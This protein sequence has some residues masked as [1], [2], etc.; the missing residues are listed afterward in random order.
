VIALFL[1]LLAAPKLQPCQVPG[2]DE[3]VHCGRYEVYENRAAR[4]GRK[5]ALKIVVL[6]ATG[7]RATSDPLVFLAGG[8]VAPATRY[9]AF[10]GNA[11]PNLR[12]QRDILLVDQ[13]G[14]GGSN[15]LDCEIS[16]DRT[17]AEYRDEARFRA[18]VRRC[19]AQLEAKADVR[20]YTT[21]LAMDDL[22]DVRA[23]L[24]YSRLNLYGASYG[25]SAAMVYV[26]QHPTRVRTITL[27][28]VVP[29]D[30]QMWIEIPRSSEEVLRHVFAA[31]AAQHD[32]HAA[33][34]R[35]ESEFRSL[36]KRLA[37]KPEAGIDDV[38]LSDFVFKTLYSA[39]RIRDLP[40]LLHLASQGDVQPL[41]SKIAVKSDSEIPKG[42][43]LS[44]VCSELIPRFDVRDV[45]AAVAGT[46]MGDHRLQ[47]E[48]D[49]CGEWVRGPLPPRFF[50]PVTSNVPA[51]V[52][53]G[54]LDHLTPPRYGQH[55]AQSLP[56]ARHLILPRRGHNDVD[57]CITGMIEAFIA[58]G[59]AA[60]V[61]ASCLAKTEALSFDVK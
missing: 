2:V 14:T 42:V 20:L 35:L 32:C 6:P 27:Q 51:L 8:G 4:S 28:G 12:K 29:L 56:R 22:D 57:E 19:R 36:L 26:R 30:G 49:A 34:P 58:G 41:A 46:F 59:D 24:G 13:R 5:I 40:L 25:T 44:I 7:S 21:P 48:I 55:V 60:R 37:A 10:L 1:I 23:W 54:E 17:S 45:P 15:P 61:D 47:R 31:C 11:F 52:M 53:N 39:S 50:A 9:A 38:V 33:F 18:S 16:F 3:E 43:Y